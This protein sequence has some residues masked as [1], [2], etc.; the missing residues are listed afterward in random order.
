M[1]KEHRRTPTLAIWVGT[2]IVLLLSVL[3]A[4][5]I[6]FVRNRIFHRGGSQVPN[7]SGVKVTPRRSVAVLGISNISGRQDD[8]WLSTAYAS[9][10][11]TEMGAG[12][13]L[14]T[15]SG[16]EISQTKIDLA[17]PESDSYGRDTCRKFIESWM[18]I[19]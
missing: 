19:T 14:R 9:A 18:L 11:T 12:E 3:L 6:N 15:I 4:T 2:I 13:Q 7:A 17:L 5:N 16:E 8:N 1:A 10:L